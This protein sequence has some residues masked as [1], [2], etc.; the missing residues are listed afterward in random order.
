MPSSM[1]ILYPPPKADAGVKYF[2]IVLQPSYDIDTILD[3]F[4]EH[5]Q[6][7]HNDFRID[8]APLS[9]LVGYTVFGFGDKEGWPTEEEG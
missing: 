8:T 7:T 2:Y 6:E 3:N 5:L 4:T 1:S 9:S